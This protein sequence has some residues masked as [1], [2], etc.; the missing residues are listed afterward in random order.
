MWNLAWGSG[1]PRQISPLSV[2]KCGNT[3]SKTVAFKFLVWLHS[4]E[5][6]PNYKD[7]PAVGA[8]SHK[9]SVASS[10]ETTDRIK[11]KLERCKNGTDLL[12]HHAPYGGDRGSRADCRRKS[13]MFFCLS[14]FGMTKIVITETLWSGVIFKT[15]MMSLHRGR[16]VVVHLYSTFS[17][18]P[19]YFHIWANL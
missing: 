13:V 10:G 16:F 6:Q 15:I 9:F 17:V 2:K 11:K 5:K 12:Y 18:D 14:R 19:R 1:S 8:F 3:A 4:G 7:F